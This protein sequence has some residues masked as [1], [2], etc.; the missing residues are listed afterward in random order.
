MQCSAITH[1]NLAELH[2]GLFRTVFR[3]G[4][5]Q[6]GGRAPDLCEQHTGETGEQMKQ[7]KQMILRDRSTCETGQPVK[8]VN[9]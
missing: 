8:Q 4:S 7:V 9:L 3:G 5:F 6:G 1:P 2:H